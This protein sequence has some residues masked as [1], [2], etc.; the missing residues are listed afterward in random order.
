M[1]HGAGAAERGGRAARRGLTVRW[2]LWAA[3]SVASPAF[4]ADPAVE[5]VYPSSPPLSI[6]DAETVEKH[7]AEVNLTLGFTGGRDGWEAEAP[8]VDANYGLTENVH[9]NAEIPLVLSGADG[10]VTAGLGRGAAAVK[11]RFVHTD[12]VQLAVHP[13][14]ELPP[15]PG[16][17]ADREGTA[18]VT[19]PVVL[20]V[21]LGPSGAGLGV[22]LSHT[23]TGTT[24]AEGWG[25]EDGWGAA[26]GFA[27][28]L[29]TGT[30]LGFDYTQEAA[31]DVT[32]GEGWFE[33]GLVHERLF[34]SEALTL[35]ASLG[36]STEGRT[37]AMLGVQVGL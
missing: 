13:A 18:S 16:V 26:V 28:P 2:A 11:V 27:T 21:A 31:A 10:A 24:G 33:A 7:H 9:V 6:D 29:A 14:V 5:A 1:G 30:V 36:R 37:A 15:L 35:L 20:D 17:S 32:L 8:L 25:A 3:A 12:R 19:L 4:A 34:G 23:F 22:Q